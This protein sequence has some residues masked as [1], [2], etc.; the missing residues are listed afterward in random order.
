MP[1]AKGAG[2]GKKRDPEG[3]A[4]LQKATMLRMDDRAVC[5]VARCCLKRWMRPQVTQRCVGALGFGGRFALCAWLMH[6]I[7]PYGWA[8]HAAARRRFPTFQRGG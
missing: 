7:A 3:F 1:G 8:A 5:A 2:S 6:G 4:T